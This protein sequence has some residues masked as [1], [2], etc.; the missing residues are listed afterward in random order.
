MRIWPTKRTRRR[1]AR[2]LSIA[3]LSFAAAGGAVAALPAAATA[4]TYEVYMCQD[5][6]GTA[7]LQDGWSEDAGKALDTSAN[8]DQPGG[9]DGK[10]DGLQVWSA[11]SGLGSEAGAYWL[12]A[13]AGTTI[14]GLTYEGMFSSYGGWVAHWAT[15][16][17]GGGD[18]T[19]DCGTTQDCTQGTLSGPGGTLGDSSYS[20]PNASL[21]GF[22]LWCDAA[23]CA[24]NSADSLFGPAGSANVLNAT[25]TINEPTP[26]SL[27]ISG[28]PPS[29]ISNANAPNGG[30]QMAAQASDPGGVCDLNLS[31]GPLT[32]SDDVTPNFGSA[33]PC[34]TGT[35][36]TTIDLNPCE[37]GG[38]GSGSYPASASA[39]NPAGMW[40]STSGGQINVECS[41]PALSVSST[42]NLGAW[43]PGPQTVEVA[44]SDESGLQGDLDCTV[45]Q[46][47]VS[48]APSQLPYALAVTQNGATSVSC[49]AENNVDYST[50]SSLDGQV[51]IDSQVPSVA[52]S[53]ST[54][55]PA[56]V[57]GPQTVTVNGSEAQQLSGIS[58]VSCQLDGGGWT[59][60]DGPVASVKLTSNGT[61]TIAC[62]ATTGAGVNSATRTDTVQIDSAPPTIG[63]S[64]G[65][66]QSTFSM[67]AESIDVTATKPAGS[68]GVA[69]ISCTINDQTSTYTNSGSTPDSQTVKVTVQPPGGDLSCRAQDNAGN[70]STPQA[71][72]FLID[73][74]T[75]T[76][77][78]LPP[79]PSNP[80]QV[81]VQ[82]ADA[83]SGVARVQ[84][85]IQTA[86]GWDPLSTAF[87]PSTGIAT[88]TIPDNGSLADGTYQ[89]QALVWSVAGNE[90]TISQEPAGT[91]GAL[92]PAAVTLPLRIVTQLLVGPVQA[93]ASIARC[94]TARVVV[95]RADGARHEALA[96][97]LVER[98]AAVRIQRRETIEL[99]YGQRATVT[100]TLQ[101]VDGTPIPDAGIQITQQ[102][103]G[104]TAQPGGQ[105]TTDSHGRFTYPLAPGASRTV[106][107]SYPGTAVLRA[108]SGSASVAVQG[109]ATL[110]ITP[111]RAVAGRPLRMS[112]SVFGGYIP[113]GGVLVQLW[114]S[115]Q[116]LT[117]PEPF[118]AA[119]YTNSKGYWSTSFP[120]NRQARGLIYHFFAV[121]AKQ[122]GWPYAASDSNVVTRRVT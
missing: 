108:S 16:E 96:A 62:Y 114:F 1:L 9:S 53:G 85:E 44:A 55:A 8:C 48:L 66:D 7:A 50:T 17:G 111:K 68:S 115:I 89:L 90:A 77:E 93:Q 88:A 59:T 12:H 42:E 106:T 61:H 26:P 10:G 64:D 87:D 74:T 19:G 45:G 103:T 120:L 83:L 20:V 72:D 99:R 31:V 75:P 49:R 119:I 52:F 81:S 84:I 102:A 38:L 54:P 101:T 32:G 37:P 60:S 110:K 2:G 91:S 86:T 46:Q 82:V 29:W 70:W 94:V 100:G 3:A 43:Y 105:V 118:H 41:G 116:N 117:P 36:G 35:Q 79:D 112:G 121:I 56:W 27:T 11:S 15:S 28:S 97:K 40:S 92:Q 51:N 33:T 14:T 109:K 23:T 65:P 58:S 18:P 69:Q 25:V 78:F 63:F 104:W 24:Q 13:P 80:T 122:S 6:Y 34:R 47:T 5:G 30:W 73:N 39:E 76:G 95:R 4:G 113:P 22:G 21:I 57:S 71:W 67:T 98:C 107:F